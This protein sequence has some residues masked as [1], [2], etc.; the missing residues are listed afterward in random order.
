M[1]PFKQPAEAK[2]Q[3]EDWFGL[4]DAFGGYISKPEVTN[5]TPNYLVPGS[6]NVLIDYSNRVVS[7]PGYKLYNQ[8]NNGGPGIQGSYEWETSTGSQFSLRAYG[9]QLEFDWNGTYNTLLSNLSSPIIE[10]AKV[11]DYNEQQDVLLG[12]NGTSGMLRWSGGASKVRASTTTTLTKQ[13]VIGQQLGFVGTPTVTIASPGI[14]T[15]ASHGL[16]AGNV[17]QFSTTGGLP[18]GILPGV[19]YYVIATGL[20][21]N[22]FEVST[23]LSGSA[24]N[25]SG[26]QSGT[27]SVYLVNPTNGL[28]ISFVASPT[29]G[30]VA[31]TILDS[32]NNFLNAGFAP[33]DTINITGSVGNSREYTIA[34]LTAGVITLVMTNIL[35]TEAAGQN[36]LIYNQTGPTW[37]SARFFSTISP[38]SISYK[39]VSYAYTGGE[40]TDTLTGLS[41]FPTV[42]VGDSVWQ[43]PD[44]VPLPSAVTS[45]FPNFYPNLIGVQLNMVFLASISSSMIFGSKSI[46]YTDF[47]LS[48]PRPP[49][50]PVQQPLT[51][52]PCTCII[53]VDTDAMILNVQSTLIFGSGRDAFDQIDFHMSADNSEELLRIIRYKTAVGSGL[54]SK[55][56]I[57]PIRNNTVY[58]SREPALT[59]L[60]EAGLEAPDGAKNV[61]ISDPIKNDFDSYDFTGAHIK[62]WKRALF[63]ALPNEGLVLIYDMMRNMWHPPATMPISRLGVI[64]DQLI[65]HS[66]VNNETY[67][68]FV[69]TNDNGNRINFCA[70]FAYNNGGRRDRLKNMS[71]NWTDGYISSNGILNMVLGIGFE[72]ST[73]KWSFPILGTDSS[74]ITGRQ[75]TPLGNGP[76]GSQ[77]LGGADINSPQGE[78]AALYRFHQ[79][80]TVQQDDYFEYYTEYSMNVLDG[81]FAIVAHGSDQYDAGTSPNSIKK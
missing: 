49:G 37:K 1:T 30:T 35:V 80:D 8:A 66:A 32:N 3:P 10:F 69:G 55:D 25:T 56:A 44:T 48:P 27:H 21:T 46:D 26:S 42:A 7:R 61:P 81:Q 36:I 39:G 41:S 6:K 29:Y 58:I 28:G 78:G 74:I 24:V 79:V 50:D 33:G 15:L 47:T 59:S 2:T 72:A 76:F 65:G 17:V 12:V 62:Y 70:R 71:E 73:K 43:T 52:G 68:L 20:D 18:T 54:L 60:S 16:I 5:I 57:C 13:G 45:P 11:L 77:P 75:A 51:S 38:R 22:D 67:Q 31:A 64:K 9:Q 53:P 40:N 4:I 23:T 63:I 14:F 34:T 19:N